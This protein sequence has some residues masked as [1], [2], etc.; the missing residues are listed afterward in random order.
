M[1]IVKAEKT[2]LEELL[3]LQYLAYASEAEIYDDY[4]IP[5][6]VQTL[7]ELQAEIQRSTCLV[8]KQNDVIIASVRAMRDGDLCHVG[9]LVVHP[10]FQG[11]GYGSKMMSAIESCHRDSKVFEVF[12]GHKSTRNLYLYSKLGYKNYSQ[13]QLN[14]KVNLVF[15]RKLSSA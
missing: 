13:T 12:T 1:N 6:L 3:K 15:L 10:D 8:V 14:E 7:E 5:P 2:D 11:K 4:T 9:K